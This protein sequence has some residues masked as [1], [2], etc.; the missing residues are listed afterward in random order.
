[1]DF[2]RRENTAKYMKTVKK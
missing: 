2:M 1:M